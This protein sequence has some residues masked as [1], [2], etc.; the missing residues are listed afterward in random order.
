MVKKDKILKK[1]RFLGSVNSLREAIVSEKSSTG[2]YQYSTREEYIG[3]VL[4]IVMDKKEKQ[5]LK[6]DLVV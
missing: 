5:F 1:S 2:K 3:K 6:E 4:K